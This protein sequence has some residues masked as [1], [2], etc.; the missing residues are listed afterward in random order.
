MV[1]IGSSLEAL[2]S[3]TFT[4]PHKV[5]PGLKPNQLNFQVD[6]VMFVS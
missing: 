5:G 1:R 3:Q 2:K 4:R 6:H